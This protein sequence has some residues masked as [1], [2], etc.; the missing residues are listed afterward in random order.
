MAKPFRDNA[1]KQT[2]RQHWNAPLLSHLHKNYGVRFRYLGLPGVDL[3]DVLMWKSMIEE[4]IAFEP[5][6]KFGDSRQSITA[7]RRNLSIHNIN[8]YAY[9]GSFEEVVMLRKDFEGKA[10]T[11]GKLVTLYNLDF[12]DEI[13]SA[14]ATSEGTRKVWRFEAI[15]QVLADQ[16]E[17][18]RQDQSQDY[19]LIFLT[20]RNQIH[21]TK[22]RQYL[23]KSLFEETSNYKRA[24][25]L[26]NEIPSDHVYL[27][28]SHTWALKAFIFNSLCQFFGNPVLDVLFFPQVLYD[29]TPVKPRDRY[30]KVIEGADLI[31]SPMLHWM[32]LCRF[33][34]P[35]SP[36]G[37]IYPTPYLPKQSVR[38]LS[39]GR[40]TWET[41]HGEGELTNDPVNP[42]V[43][44]SKYGSEILNGIQGRSP[45]ARQSDDG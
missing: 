30:G 13:S 42:T 26:I 23:R 40:L 45:V 3:L 29:G 31:P 17:C 33:S 27:N 4:V 15:R 2:V 16:K 12:C 25:D 41:Q 14:V 5:P 38:A 10:Y 36:A 32:V 1:P 8:G 43:W 19:F 20:V 21:S 22:V 39:S 7:L 44:L 9:Y 11:Q 34:N 24:C 28:G 35:E 18:Y 6:N 37:S